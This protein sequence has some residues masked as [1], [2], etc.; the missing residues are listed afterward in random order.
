MVCKVCTARMVCV[1]G[2]GRGPPPRVSGPAGRIARGARPVLPDTP[3][4]LALPAPLSLP[5]H[6]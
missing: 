6:C 5:D 4:A 3:R 1:V 2:K